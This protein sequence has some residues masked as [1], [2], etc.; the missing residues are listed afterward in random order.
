MNKVNYEIEMNRILSEGKRSVF[1]HCC[2]GP[3]ATA[4]VERIKD[5]CNLT[6]FYYNPCIEDQ[7]EYEKRWQNL[8]KVADYFSVNAIKSTSYDN[9]KFR[10]VSK[11][12]ESEKEGGAR[13]VECFYL[14]L[15]ETAKKAKEYG[16]EYFCTT[17]TISP[18]KNADMINALG[19][20]IAQEEG[21]K[22]LYSDFKKKG[23]FLQSTVLSKE[24]GLYRQDYCGCSYGRQREN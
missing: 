16:Y 11:G 19:E 2:C 8:Q 22:W 15:K 4:V 17:L 21:I 1:M 9:E 5:D 12:Y 7:E 13:C 23:G 3:C 18:H 10:A 14:R 20:R 24:L 6:L